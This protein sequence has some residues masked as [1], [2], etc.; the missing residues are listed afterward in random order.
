MGSVTPLTGSVLD[1]DPRYLE[2][3]V[4]ADPA[5]TPRLRLTSVPYAFFAEEAGTLGGLDSTAFW[6]LGGNTG[7]TPGTDFLGTND[8]QDLVI[9][10]NG[11]E[12][13]RI[14]GFT[15]NVGIGTSPS[16]AKLAVNGIIQTNLADSYDKIRV[17][18]S[19]LYTIGFKSAQSLGFLNDFATT[20]TMND[21]PDRGWLWRDA[22]D[23]V[24]DGAMSLTTDG[25]LYVKSTAAFNGNVGIGTTAPSAKLDVVG[26]V[27]ATDFNYSTAQTEY[28]MIAGSQ[29]QGRNL[30]TFIADRPFFCRLSQS[31]A[32]TDAYWS[33]NLP[34]GATVTGFQVQAWQSSGTMTCDLRRGLNNL[35]S[36]MAN[37]T[38]ASAAW[39]WSTEDT[40]ISLNPIDTSTY[41][42]GVH[43]TTS[44]VAVD[45]V[46]GAIRIRY[47]MPGP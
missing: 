25:R 13:V 37:V 23:V 3:K 5:M 27:E 47:T 11:T 15:G 8:A 34:N 35:G 41:A 10:T 36:D 24:S 29:C 44:A 42:Y 33:V 20:F 38:R 14:N 17:F 30:D 12:R 2:V 7:T 31:T 9:K 28:L 39:L 32:D 45:S 22:S 4:G 21:D 16:S 6:M 43:C 1:G 40:T 26:V 19:S 46:V 18:T